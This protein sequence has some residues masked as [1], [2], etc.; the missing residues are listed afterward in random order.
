MAAASIAA[1]GSAAAA[2]EGV[3]SRTASTAAAASATSVPPRY[4]NLVHGMY[5]IWVDEGWRGY[6]RGLAPK[7][8]QP[9]HMLMARNGAKAVIELPLMWL[10]CCVSV[11]LCVCVRVRLSAQTSVPRRAVRLQQP[12]VR[13]GTDSVDEGFGEGP[14]V[15]CPVKSAAAS[16]F[17]DLTHHHLI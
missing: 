7:S 1:P 6:T 9:H 5:R 8:D 15:P 12:D 3:A 16:V 11:C 14:Q 17:F 13:S 4:R 2:A 10:V